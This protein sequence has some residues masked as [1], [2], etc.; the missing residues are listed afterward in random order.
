MEKLIVPFEIKKVEDSG[1]YY[2]FEGYGNTWDIDYGDDRSVK[3]CFK[4]CIERL[5]KR[6]NGKGILPA[7]WQHNATEPVGVYM[8]LYE[9]DFGLFVKGIMPKEDD[10]VRGRVM[11]QIKV[12]SVS[13]MSIGYVVKEY[14][15]VDVDGKR[16]RNLEEV[17]LMEI[18]LVTFPMNQGASITDYKSANDLCPIAP[19]GTEWDEKEAETVFNVPVFTKEIDGK[20]MI[21]PKG[22]FHA[23]QVLRGL[24]GEIEITDEERQ[25]V[26]SSIAK[27]YEKMGVGNPLRDGYLLI[28]AVSVK[29][30]TKRELEGILTS[31][32]VKF[33]ANASKLILKGFDVDALRDE[34]KDTEREA[35]QVKDFEE[36]LNNLKNLGGHN[37]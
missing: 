32:K 10:F 9:D 21:I 7:L 3:G 29:N 27:V 37:A 8:E 2:E 30:L 11:P 26:E 25:A 16:V 18:S 24:K 5:K 19:I 20:K 17:E 14:S 31:E 33:S 23:C 12:G 6:S 22:V 13:K 36:M 34:R 28:D 1:E 15:Y 35:R 4:G